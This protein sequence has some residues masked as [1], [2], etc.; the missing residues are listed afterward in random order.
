MKSTLVVL[1]A[2][3][4]LLAACS[5]ATGT[6][7]NSC[8]P[9]RAEVCA[10]ADGR[11]GSQ[12]C[13]ADRTTFS[14]C[15]CVDTCTA[16]TCSTHG[17][18]ALSG[19]TPTCSCFGA[20][21]GTHCEK[22]AP[23]AAD[24]EG[25]GSCAF[26]TCTATS[27]SGHGTC[28]V[29][30]GAV[31]C[32]CFAAYQGATCSACAA[33][34]E[35]V[36]GSGSCEMQ[37]CTRDQCNGHGSC[38]A[39]DAGVGCS[40]FAAYTGDTCL[41][42]ATGFQDHDGDGTCEPACT[43]SSCSGHGACADA[44]GAPQCT[45][46]P[47]YVGGSCS[48]CAA[49]FQDKNGDGV[50]APDCTQA[51]LSCGSLAVCA[52]ETGTAVCKCLQGYVASGTQ[53][54]G[55][56]RCLWSGVV[57]DPAFTFTPAV[58]AIAADAGVDL[59]TPV[60][61]QRDVGVMTVDQQSVL[62]P[63]LVSQTITLPATDIPWGYEANFSDGLGLVIRLDREAVQLKNNTYL[64]DTFTGCFGDRLRSGSQTLALS[65]AQLTTGYASGPLQ[66]DH[67]EIRPNPDCPAPGQVKNGDFEAAGG[68]EI[69]GGDIGPVSSGSHGLRFSFGPC[70]FGLASTKVSI[71]SAELMPGA[72]ISVRTRFTSTLGGQRSL[73]LSTGLEGNG[74]AITPGANWAS[75]TQCV[76]ASLRGKVVNFLISGGAQGD[77]AP[78]TGTMDLEF[79]DATLV[80]DPACAVSE[81][82]ID[83][84]FEAGSSQWA[85][86]SGATRVGA[87]HLGWYSMQLN[88]VSVCDFPTA[89]QAVRVP[90]AVPGAGPALKLFYK[91]Q[92]SQAT[93][94]VSAGPVSKTLPNA[95]NW[96]QATV[97][98]P[99]AMSGLATYVMVSST[100][101][102]GSCATTMT[103]QTANVDDLT[104]TTDPSCP[105]Q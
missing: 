68:W 39:G 29:A 55:Q 86:F 97:C 96:T 46:Q 18:C 90:D 84:G 58:W 40:C 22:C 105:W 98:F 87:S 6:P 1:L 83:P 41:T 24:L 38:G 77:C 7:V 4:G 45:C 16:T 73:S 71:P 2:S 95:T 48:V 47:G 56:L 14:D 85:L 69:S 31:S 12:T 66:L 92:T 82:F 53:A 27:C 36:K 93:F 60:F 44:R 72:A 26:A 11:I 94:S 43:A 3:S 37:A 91:A 25:D 76:P 17:T 100:G 35:D 33:G 88:P 21:S 23:T 51:A 13:N 59:T 28:A 62:K 64:R 57:G 104:L 81:G 79:D 49:G 74:V 70:S 42:C 78:A 5:S 63:N 19:T 10:C 34:F 65:S 75:T 15:V 103:G 67:F 101:P 52:D 80:G 8:V 102:G 61:G 20:Y 50:C 9:N 89:R 99:P 32:T 30:Q 54:N